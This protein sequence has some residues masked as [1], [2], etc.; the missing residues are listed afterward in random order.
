MNIAFFTATWCYGSH[1]ENMPSPV[2][3]M[4][5]DVPHTTK[6]GLAFDLS[7]SKKNLTAE[8]NYWLYFIVAHKADLGNQSFTLL[9]TK[10]TFPDER[11]ADL[12]A[13]TIVIDEAKGR[14]EEADE[15][16]R[17]L[18]VPFLTEGWMLL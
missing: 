17:P 10:Q 11:L 8:H 13:S 14:L 2:T 18:R 16:G 6:R 4:L 1:G 15:T 7:L 5:Q 3:E 12:L 9:A